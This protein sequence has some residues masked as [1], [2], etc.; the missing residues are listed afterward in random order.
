MQ[1]I[2]RN[3]MRGER[4]LHFALVGAY[5]NFKSAI[6]FSMYFFV[7][8]VNV[9]RLTGVT[10]DSLTWMTYSVSKAKIKRILSL[11]LCV[12]V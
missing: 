6:G 7:V 12:R 8:M 3:V 9:F 4:F 2:R 11:H 5:D 1:F 10:I